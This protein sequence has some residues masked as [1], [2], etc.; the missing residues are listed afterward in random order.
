[1]Q[2][3]CQPTSFFSGTLKESLVAHYP[4][5]RNARDQIGNG[6]NGEVHSATLTSDRFGNSNAAYNFDGSSFYIQVNNGLPFDF[7]NSFSVAF[8]VKPVLHQKN[9]A[10]IF[11]K[12]CVID[13]SSSW[14]V[15]Q[16]NQH[17]NYFHFVYW[18]FSTNSWMFS[19]DTLLLPTRWNH[20]VITK[21]NSQVKS[22]LNGK[23]LSLAFGTNSKIKTNGNSPLFMGI[24]DP[25][26]F[27]SPTNK[28]YFNGSLD[29]IFIYNHIITADEVLKLYQF[30]AP[31][32]QPTSGPTS[33]PSD[34][35]SIRPIN[36]PSNQACIQ[37]EFHRFSFLLL[38]SS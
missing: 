20:Y 26:Q 17:T 6:N 16:N 33:Q 30:D 2:P 7:S 31:T 23:L 37:P 3:T 32:S 36:Y 10:T 28:Y 22:Y 5:D 25:A 34:K 19:N 29:D 38:F 35:P 18:Q 24:V 4:F 11:S 15:E 21:Q 12:S 8:W 9:W 1:L 14:A 13:G 27:V